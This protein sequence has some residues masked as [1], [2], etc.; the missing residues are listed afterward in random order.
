M[1]CS[2]S[3][4]N[5]TEPR[6]AVLLYLH[7]GVILIT[8]EIMAPKQWPES[9]MW[10]RVRPPHSGNTIAENVKRKQEPGSRGRAGGSW[11]SQQKR[12]RNCSPSPGGPFWGI[13]L[14]A[15]FFFYSLGNRRKQSFV[16]P[17][18]WDRRPA[19]VP[20]PSC[21]QKT[22]ESFLPGGRDWTE[23]NGH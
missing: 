10:F 19:N 5:E 8:S 6:L 14:A 4:Q 17:G 20:P 1:E 13:F 22:T 18:G 15:L 11:H 2:P 16:K 9:S 3:T 12:K 21:A 7:K 23:L